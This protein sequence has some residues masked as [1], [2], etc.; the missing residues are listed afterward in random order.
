MFIQKF[1]EKNNDRSVAFVIFRCFSPPSFIDMFIKLKWLGIQPTRIIWVGPRHMFRHHQL[2]Y[3]GWLDYIGGVIL[4]SYLS[5]RNK[6]MKS[7]SLI[8]QAKWMNMEWQQTTS[9]DNY[10]T[11][12]CLFFTQHH[13]I[14]KMTWTDQSTALLSFPGR[15][16]SLHHWNA[17]RLACK[18][19][20]CDFFFGGETVNI[21]SK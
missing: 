19:K 10:W 17:W 9:S 14:H 13:I 21:S 1:L 7:G 6:I 5:I 2:S 8:N 20:R 15:P 18:A 11:N 16:A 12:Q 3:R 4:H